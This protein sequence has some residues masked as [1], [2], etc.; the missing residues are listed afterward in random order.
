MSDNQF[1]VNDAATNFSKT[2]NYSELNNAK[3]EYKYN[4]ACIPSNATNANDAQCIRF[5]PEKMPDTFDCD[6]F[7]GGE[8][9]N[10]TEQEGLTCI[11]NCQGPPEAK[12]VG[13]GVTVYP[14]FVLTF[15][16]LLMVFMMFKRN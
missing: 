2:C 14:S 3:G 7:F 11:G 15:A 12:A 10:A 9:R 13:A 1:D 16:A 8:W 6:Y 4:F 5:A